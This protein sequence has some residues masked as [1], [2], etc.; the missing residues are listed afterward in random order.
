MIDQI[1]FK[2]GTDLVDGLLE[3]LK[4]LES[5]LDLKQPIQMYIAGGMAAHLYTGARVTTD[6]DAEFS[7]RFI[8]P[9]DLLVETKGGQVLYLDANYNSTFALLHEDYIRDAIKV[10]IDSHLIEVYVLSPVDLVV[11]KIARY[12]GPDAGDIEEI[13][14][15]KLVTGAEIEVRA[16]KALTGYIGNTSWVQHNL[17]EV[18]KVARQ[19]EEVDDSDDEDRPGPRP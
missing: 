18:L 3:L 17:N 1:R 15:A 19:L 13:L 9:A 5:S 6:V 14:K 10:P 7:K 2:T 12:S 16:K 4:R 8:M 11:S